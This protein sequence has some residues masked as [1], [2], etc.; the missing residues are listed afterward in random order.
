MAGI[1]EL[2]TTFNLP[3]YTG[4][5]HQLSPTATPFFS[6]IGGLSN[7]GG[8]T[9]DLEFEWETE[10][11]RAPGQNVALEGADAPSDQNRVRGNVSNIVEIH[12][13][14]VGVSYSKLAA[15]AKKAGLNNESANPVRNEL[16]YQVSRMLVQMIRDVNWAFWNGKYNKPSDNTGKRQTRGLLQAITT[17]A[18]TASGAVTLTGA[19]SATDTITITHALAVGD[20]VVFTAIGA[21]AGITLGQVYYVKSVSTTV[22]FKVAATASGPA[23][24]LG[25]ATGINLI[26]ASKTATTQ[27]VV[28]GLAQA[29]W[30]NGGID[31]ELTAVLA[32]NSRQ[33]VAISQAFSSD[34]RE[35]S[36]TVGGVSVSTVVTDFGTLGVM[37]DRALPQDMIALASLGQCRPVYLETPGKGHFFAEPLAKTGAKERT[38]LYGEVGLA[39]GPES[40]H[41]YIRG[42]AIPEAV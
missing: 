33:K 1:T 32:V 38:Q 39:Y 28:N 22:S 10:D 23:I 25:T 35:A 42:L 18:L 17:N 40:A 16:D 36:R 19:T 37:I 6:A 11:L 24:T 4:V 9:S 13:E 30:E 5:L 29:V 14:T 31:N 21:A 15:V 12:H 3:N 41:G 34:Y 8:S 20:K 26:A 7:A 27:G 2:G